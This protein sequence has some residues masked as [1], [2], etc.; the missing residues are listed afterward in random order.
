MA[1][2]EWIVLPAVAPGSSRRVPVHRFGTPGARPKAYLQGSLHADELPGALALVHLLALLAEAERAGEIGDGA[3]GEVVVVP[4]VNPI[5]FAQ[6]IGHHHVGRYELGGAGNFNRGWPDL[7][8]AV[9]ARVEMQIG[10]DAQANVA[11]IREAAL[12]LNAQGEDP[13]EVG[14]LRRAVLALALDADIVLDLHCDLEALLHVYLGSDLWP[15]AADLSADLG[16]RATLLAVDSGGDPFDELFSRLWHDLAERL[17]ERG[18]VPPACLSATVELRGRADVDDETARGDARAL[19]RFLR[20]RGLLAGDP[21]PLPAPLC[22]ATAL[23]ATEVLRA[24]RAGIVTYRVAIGDTVARGDAIATL[25][26][27]MAADPMGERE[28]VRA[29]TD[30]LVLSIR[31]D[32][33]ARPGDSIAKIA[34]TRPVRS[35]RLSED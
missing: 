31:P 1:A 5:G 29:G 2:L 8:D 26:D 14:T 4:A 16:S 20:R 17:G 11:R 13:S 30:G 32:R 21:G 3:G 19:L 28:T 18:P 27:P 22:E 7:S 34:G 33:L 10:P 9:A 12:A 24:P 25:T 6:W 35:G 23:E 15:D